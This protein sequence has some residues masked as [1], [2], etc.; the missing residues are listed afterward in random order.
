MDPVI[1]IG[2]LAGLLTTLSSLPQ[3]LKSLKTKKTSD[4]S[5]WWVL[6]LFSGVGLWLA[7]GIMVS[8]LPLIAANAVSILLVGALIALK[9]RFG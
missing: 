4:I 1:V 7:Y 6:L 5:V 8:D 2:L 3:V 9:I